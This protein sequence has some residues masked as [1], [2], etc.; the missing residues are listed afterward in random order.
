MTFVE[1][2]VS[3]FITRFLNLGYTNQVVV[4]NVPYG[5]IHNFLVRVR[6]SG[7]NGVWSDYSSPMKIDMTISM[8]ANRNHIK[9]FL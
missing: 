2:R 5:K 4:N 9:I 6:S 8:F 1:I 3:R 7:P